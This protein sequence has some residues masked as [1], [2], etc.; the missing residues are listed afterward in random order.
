MSHLIFLGTKAQLV[1]MAPVMLALDQEG[2]DYVF[3]WSGQH[4]ETI[5]DLIED[6]G[7]RSPDIRLIDE[8]EKNSKI[9]LFGWLLKSLFRL[10]R[11]LKKTSYQSIVVHGDTLSALVGGLIGNLNKMETV[12]VE[13]GLTSGHLLQPFPEE[14]VRRIVTRLSDVY[15]CQD[16]VAYDRVTDLG[17]AFLTEGNSLLDAVNIAM[18]RDKFG[19]DEGEAGYILVSIHRVENVDSSSLYDLCE[20][21]IDLSVSYRVKFVLHSVTREKLVQYGFLSKLESY[22]IQLLSRSNYSVFLKLISRSRCLITDGG[23][24]Q[25]ECFYLGHPCLIWRE[26]TERSEGLGKNAILSGKNPVVAKDFV[27]NAKQFD[28]LASSGLKS[29]SRFIAK[30]IKQRHDS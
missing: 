10:H 8:D 21:L 3:C 23:S 22:S 15:F 19:R 11:L 9:K 14:L 26:E 27:E 24:N 4:Q 20:L 5:A 30:I 17:D 25:E 16:T 18:G 1:K 7:I 13:A 12:H 6:F 2:V 28:R 29:P